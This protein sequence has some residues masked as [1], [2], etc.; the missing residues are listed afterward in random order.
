[1]YAQ[2]TAKSNNLLCNIVYVIVM[3]GVHFFTC[4]GAS[5]RG[6]SSVLLCCIIYRAATD[7]AC[8][9]GSLLINMQK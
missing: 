6:R 3:R 9:L 7:F 5:L 8:G 2:A 1:M 4:A